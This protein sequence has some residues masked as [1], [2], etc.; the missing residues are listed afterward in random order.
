MPRALTF[1]NLQDPETRKAA[2]KALAGKAGIYCIRRLKDGK[3]Y[4]GSAVDLYD[5]MCKHLWQNGGL[6]NTHLQAAI[7]F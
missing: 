5:R 3:C 1:T 2:K 4:V 7:A 6:S